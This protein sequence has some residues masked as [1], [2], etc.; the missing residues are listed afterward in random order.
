M[1]LG[2]GRRVDYAGRFYLMYI[3]V[4][5]NQVFETEVGK[6]GAAICW[7]NYMPLYRV[8]LYSKGRER[9]SYLV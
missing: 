7:E 1:C 4:A 8:N 3:E 6:I 9:E 2:T 5:D